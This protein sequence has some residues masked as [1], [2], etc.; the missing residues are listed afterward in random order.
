LFEANATMTVIPPD[1]DPIWNYRRPAVAA[2][3][4]AA[5]RML[6]RRAECGPAA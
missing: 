1:S 3:L 4:G 5:Q 2:V 6:V